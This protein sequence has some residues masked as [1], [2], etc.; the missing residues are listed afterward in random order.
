M[1][2]DQAWLD[3]ISRQLT[4]DV[5]ARLEENYWEAEWHRRYAL[6]RARDL[7]GQVGFDRRLIRVTVRWH[8]KH[9]PYSL[10]TTDRDRYKFEP[11]V[12]VWVADAITMLGEVVDS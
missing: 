2:L 12:T 8:E 6:N 10:A 11:R 3:T 5:Q 4:R 9:A 1:T 7:A